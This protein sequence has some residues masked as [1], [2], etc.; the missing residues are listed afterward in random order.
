MTNQPP[1][2]AGATHP[3]MEVPANLPI[4]YIN[5]VRIAHSPTDMVF[6][7]AQLLPGGG[8]NVRT[9]IV[10]SP[11]GAKL[12]LRAFTENLAKFEVAFGEITIPGDPTL[13]DNLFHPPQPPDKPQQK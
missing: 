13:A 4:E 11:L 8:A 3:P 1:H 6:D 5:V 10:M 2:P 7:F 12:F 9:R